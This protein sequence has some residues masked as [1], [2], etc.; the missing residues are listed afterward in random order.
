VATWAKEIPWVLISLRAQLRE[1]IGLSLAEAVFVAP[2]V[3]Q[4]EFLQGD[5]I[6]VDT[7][8][9]IKKIFGCSCFFFAQA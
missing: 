3:L 7:I 9:I 1:D 5:E 8:S 2:I 4:N 6:P